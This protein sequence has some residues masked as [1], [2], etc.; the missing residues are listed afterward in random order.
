MTNDKRITK[1]KKNYAIGNY[2]TAISI[3]NEMLEEA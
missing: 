2:D 1:A 3:L